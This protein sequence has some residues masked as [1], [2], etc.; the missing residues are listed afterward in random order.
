MK[1][2]HVVL[3]TAGLIAILALVVFAAASSVPVLIAL[4]VAVAGGIA[5][6]F[7]VPPGQRQRFWA[8][9]SSSTGPLQ[10]PATAGQRGYATIIGFI[11]GGVLIASHDQGARVWGV[12]IVLFAS[13][14]WIRWVGM[15]WWRRR[16]RDT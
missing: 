1:L 3:A 14:G 11:S 12:L 15:P 5:I 16:R 7:L 13:A 4:L 6:R 8:R 2:L 10:K 9:W